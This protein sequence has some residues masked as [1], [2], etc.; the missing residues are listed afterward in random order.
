MPTFMSAIVVTEAGDTSVLQAQSLTRPSCAPNEV[1]V[2]IFAAGVNPVDTKARQRGGLLGDPT[3]FIPGCDGAGII[4]AIGSEVEHYQVGDAVFYCYGGI[5]QASGNYAEFTCVPEQYIAHKPTACNMAQAAAAPLV[6]ISAWESLF[7]RARLQ[8]GQTLFITGG[9][10]GVGHVAIQLAKEAGCRVICT[11][12]SEEKAD[13]ARS[14]GAD[15]VI[16]RTQEDVVA[17]V[18]EWTDGAGVD[19]LFDT[20]GGET[21]PPLIS[22]VANY[23]TV[24][25]LLQFPD[26][27]DWAQLRLKNITLAQELM[28]SPM[29]LNDYAAAEHQAAILEECAELMTQDKLT[30]HIDTVLPLAEAAQAHQRIELGQTTGKLVLDCTDGTLDHD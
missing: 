9:T 13:L 15:A 7:D 3:A 1:L 25:S 18:M 14:L 8:A 16:D 23:G 12:S 5:G 28:L 24:V 26:T 27:L 20:V 30:V 17:A 6:L 21:L 29:L 19:L 22:S 10:G 4:E 11:V 2:R